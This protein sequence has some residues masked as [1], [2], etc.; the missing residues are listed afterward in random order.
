MA[1]AGL[2]AAAPAFALPDPPPPPVPPD[3]YAA[4]IPDPERTARSGGSTWYWQSVLTRN[5]ATLKLE[6]ASV[7]CVG[8]HLS[9]SNLEGGWLTYSGKLM[10][11]PAGSS[12]KLALDRCYDC[13][14]KGITVP[15]ELELSVQMPSPDTVV[16]AGEPHIQGRL[17]GG[18]SCPAQ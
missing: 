4:L 8:G 11:G 18:F 3:A 9:W 16:L 7:R 1:L 15:A 10:D 12:A 2:T 5:G 13:E 6:K 14:R 17:G